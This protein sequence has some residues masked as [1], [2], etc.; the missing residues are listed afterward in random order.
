MSQSQHQLAHYL[1]LAA[2]LMSLLPVFLCFLDLFSYDQWRKVVAEAVDTHI[3]PPLVIS[4]TNTIKHCEDHGV[5]VVIPNCEGMTI[6][7][8]AF[9]YLHT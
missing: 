9:I 6:F 4:L 3:D 7:S 8:V 5:P 1:T 2:G